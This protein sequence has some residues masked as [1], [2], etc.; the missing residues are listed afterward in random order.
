LALEVG[1]DLVV[2]VQIEVQPETAALLTEAQTRGIS[3]DALLRDT[4]TKLSTETPAQGDKLQTFL[5]AMVEGAERAPVLS[6]AANE[7]AF[8]YRA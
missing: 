7:R 1:K 3:I 5:V 2:I 8:Y 4:L 6:L